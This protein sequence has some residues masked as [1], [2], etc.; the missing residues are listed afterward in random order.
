MSTTGLI[1]PF[2]R[3]ELMLRVTYRCGYDVNFFA[4]ND[5]TEGIERLSS[6]PGL[7]GQGKHKGE[8]EVE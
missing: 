2:L 1:E 5:R 4:I 3:E 7:S 6:A 8:G